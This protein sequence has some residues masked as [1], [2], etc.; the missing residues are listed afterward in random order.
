[1]RVVVDIPPEL[2]D[3]IR[4]AVQEGNYES[5]EE[6][7]ERALRTQL[8]LESSEQETLMSFG[9]AIEAGGPPER[10]QTTEQP[11]F[12][13]STQW[14]EDRSNLEDLSTFDFDVTTVDPSDAERIDMGPLWGQYNRIFPMKLSV[15][16]LAVVLAETESDGVSYQQFR[17]ETARVAREY[18]L[19]LE[20]IDDEKGRGRGEKFS[21]AFP[22][23]DKVERSL[24]RFKTH[25][26]GQIDSSRNLTGAPRIYSS[27]ILIPTPKS[28]ASPKPASN[29]LE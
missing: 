14:S 4:S 20:E 16:R 2:V 24:D 7:L 12:T 27:S 1:M 10:E 22:T 29:L 3:D 6:F 26:V 23:G 9:D 17:N 13:Q 19:R 28:S 18:G 8:K 25:F 5:P 21:A 11:S 15:R